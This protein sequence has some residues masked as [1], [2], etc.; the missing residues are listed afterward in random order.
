MKIPSQSELDALRLQGDPLADDTIARIWQESSPSQVLRQIWA[1]QNNQELTTHTL[2]AYIEAFFQ[3]VVQPILPT[4]KT[5]IAHAQHFFT[6]N[7]Q[8]YLGMLGL[9]SLPYC[10]AGEY[11]AQVLHLSERIQA[12]TEKR[13]L[14][15]TKFVLDVL[16]PDA[17]EEAGKAWVSIG[18]V[19]LLHALIR[20]KVRNL[21]TWDMRWG[22]PINQEDMLGTNFAFSWIVLRGMEKIGYS[23]TAKDRQALIDTWRV[24]GK[25]LGIYPDIM[26]EN[27]KE[28][29]WLDETIAKRHFRAS[30]VGKE[31]TQSLV[32]YL[33]PK[34][35]YQLTT[36]YMR[37][38]LG[39]TIADYL[40][41]PPTDWKLNLLRLQVL[42]TALRDYLPFGLPTDMLGGD[43]VSFLARLQEVMKQEKVGFAE[44]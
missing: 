20:Q 8:P 16:S 19:R 5:Q 34:F 1:I 44:M 23:I 27:P 14:E 13:L 11:G 29:F 12:K 4:E 9:L 18:Q 32:N 28:A 10:Y 43:S 30:T 22:L 37:Y 35:P 17:F 7:A 24:V 21:P 2:P 26:P 33:N 3:S 42:Q 41:L 36:V 31:L 38:L 6:Q 39:D 25:G 40:G 15:T